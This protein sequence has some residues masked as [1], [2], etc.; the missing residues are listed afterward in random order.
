MMKY[1]LIAVTVTLFAF[2]CSAEPADHGASD[3]VTHVIETTVKTW[4]ADALYGMTAEQFKAAASKEDVEGMFTYYKALGKLK[5][6]D[7]PD[8]QVRKERL[9]DGKEAEVGAF[10]VPAE[11]D[12][13]KATI[14]VVVIR[15]ESGWK[16]YGFKIKSNYVMNIIDAQKREPEMQM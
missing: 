2:A 1:I 3:Y 8:G 7:K 11:F 5:S 4:D 16:V 9:P 13:D 15:T 10:H 12:N 14:N 6:Y